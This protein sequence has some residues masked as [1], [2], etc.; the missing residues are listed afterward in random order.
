MMDKGTTKFFEKKS[1]PEWNQV[2]AFK[3]ERIMRIQASV[4]ELLVRDKAD[5]SSEMIGKVGFNISDIPMR[6]KLDSPLASQWYRM[7]DKNGVKLRGRELMVTRLFG[8]D[9]DSFTEH[10]EEACHWAAGI[11]N[12]ECNRVAVNEAEKKSAL[13][14]YSYSVAKCGSKWVR[15]SDRQW[16]Q[17]LSWVYKFG[18]LVVKPVRP[19]WLTSAHLSTFQMRPFVPTAEIL[20]Y[21]PFDL[22]RCWA[23]ITPGTVLII[24]AGRFMGK[25]VV[26]LKQLPSGLLLVTGPFKI[27]G[28][29]LRRVNQSYVIATS[30]K[31]DIAGVNVEKFDDKYFGKELQK[32][33]KKGEGE[34]FEAEKEEKNVLPQEKKDDQKAVDTQ[35][36]KPSRELQT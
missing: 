19:G 4:L 14:A 34:F 17:Q 24:L 11:G 12:R 28:V 32:K 29:P 22:H 30:T 13:I 8:K 33:K 3:K 27:N 1:D 16:N 26:F 6:V 9:C 18:L 21:I 10:Y 31:V 5:G 15:T 23:S 36:I 35:L 25:R 2:L 7:E 20:P